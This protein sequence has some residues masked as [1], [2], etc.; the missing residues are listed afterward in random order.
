MLAH[1]QFGRAAGLSKE[2]IS[3]LAVLA[4]DRFD[5][6][7]YTALTYVRSFLTEVD[8]V[9][10]EVEERFTETFEPTER[11]QILAAMKGMFWTNLLVNTWRWSGWK[12]LGR[13][14]GGN[15]KACVC[16]VFAPDA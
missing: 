6:R 2:Q 1:T 8:G 7:T 3:D 16:S 11:V 10:V 13:P 9:P 15:D 5:E 4:S 14:M 12:L